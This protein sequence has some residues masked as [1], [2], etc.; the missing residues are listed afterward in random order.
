MRQVQYEMED[1]MLYDRAAVE[2]H[3]EKMAAAYGR[4]MGEEELP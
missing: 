4:Y 3:L 2:R 1:F